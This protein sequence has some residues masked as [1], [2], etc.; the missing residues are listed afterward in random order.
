[1]S[2]EDFRT[3]N[4]TNILRRENQKCRQKYRQV[5]SLITLRLTR[6]SVLIGAHITIIFLLRPVKRCRADI[7]I[8]KLKSFLQGTGT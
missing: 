1:M 4:S 5:N 8:L 6:A 7:E 3:S 2:P